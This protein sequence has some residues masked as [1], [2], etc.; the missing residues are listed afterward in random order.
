MNDFRFHEIHILSFRP[1][2]NAQIRCS[3]PFMYSLYR[4]NKVSAQ[5]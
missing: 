5:N 3:Y 1:A 4:N 2:K